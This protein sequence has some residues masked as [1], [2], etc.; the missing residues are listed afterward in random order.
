MGTLA[1]RAEKLLGV[2]VVATTPVAGGDI[3]VA[4]RLRLTDGRSALIK[5]RP[6]APAGF[7]ETEAAGLRW[8]AD[9]RGAPVPDVLG[10]DD[11]CLVLSWIEP[12]RPTP[13]AAESFGRGLSRTHAAGAPTFGAE[14][15]GYIGSAPLPNTAAPDWP[16]FYAEQRVRP[17]LRL[18]H[19]RGRLADDDRADVETLLTR[20]SEVAG[21][22]EDPARVHGDLWSG[23][24]VW[25][26]APLGYSSAPEH[27]DGS[28]ASPP[29]PSGPRAHLVD[30]AAHGGHR[31]TDL[32]MLALFGVPYLDR[33]LA[34]YD[35]ATPLADGWA[36]RVPLHQ[37]H[38]LL[39][40]AAT[41]G[42]G[43]GSRAAAAAR[44]ALHS[45]AP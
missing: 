4:T 23:N 20:L 13:D 36:G 15:D 40:H 12:G 30:P 9:A 25:G 44:A 39:V 10:V 31:E 11:D 34:A 22:A 3:C 41:F 1:A 32:A 26:A 29:V 27:P 17:Y 35:E 19:D 2:P 14:T 18:A 16:T 43:Y 38:P 45:P 6:H 42:G 7:F 33:I 5:T 28:G 24:V 21:P 37:V 8:L